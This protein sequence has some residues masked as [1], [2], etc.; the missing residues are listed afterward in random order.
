MAVKK[1]CANLMVLLV[2]NNVTGHPAGAW[3]WQEPKLMAQAVVW[4]IVDLV[5][6]IVNE[7]LMTKIV[8]GMDVSRPSVKVMDCLVHDNVTVQ[9]VR[10]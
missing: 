5:L 9:F 4:P 10:V 3:I 2:L 7:A 1:Q 8:V 6:V